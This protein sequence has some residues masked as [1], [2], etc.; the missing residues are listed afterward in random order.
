VCG[1]GCGLCVLGGCVG[2]VVECLVGGFWWGGG[3]RLAC[4]FVGWGC[5]VVVVAG[6]GEVSVV[7]G[8]VWRCSGGEVGVCVYG[9][10]VVGGGVV[11]ACW[12]WLICC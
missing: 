4:R 11:C 1:V 6:G 12:F 2:V 10:V 3:G 7:L 5:L 8:C 9:V